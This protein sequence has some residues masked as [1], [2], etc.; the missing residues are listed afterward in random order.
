LSAKSKLFQGAL[1]AGVMF[2][3]ACGFEPL[4]M[5]SEN[6]NGS[7]MVEGMAIERIA[8]REGQIL[9]NYLIDFM[10]PVF[11]GNIPNP[12]SFLEVTLQ[13]SQSTVAVR[14]DGTTSRYQINCTGTV[15]LWDAERKKRLIHETVRAINSYS[16]GEVS[17]GAAYSTAISEKDALHKTLRLMAEEIQ[18][19]VKTHPH[20]TGQK[21][22]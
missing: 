10:D 5:R 1:L 19:I 6:T 13:T 9:R 22:L 21:N 20:V 8:N 7:A 4:H 17:A 3:N 11:E 12:T 18:M 2:L 15:T 16:V 14:K